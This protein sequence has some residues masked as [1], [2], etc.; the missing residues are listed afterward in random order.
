MPVTVHEQEDSRKTVEHTSHERRY[1]IRGTADEQEAITAL[2]ADASCPQAYQGMQRGD[3]DVWPDG[4][5]T[6][7]AAT[8]RWRARVVWEP[9]SGGNLRNV[10]DETV[11]F[12]IGGGTV[13]ITHSIA[14]VATYAVAGETAPDFKGGIG[15]NGSYFEGC[16]IGSGAEGIVFTKTRLFAAGQITNEYLSKV[17]ALRLHTNN[18]PFLGLAQGEVLFLGASGGTRADGKVEI[19]FRFSGSK[20]KADVK[21]CNDL[22]TV[23][24][25]PGWAYVW[26]WF[27]D[28]EQTVGGRKFVKPKPIAAYVERVHHEGDFANLGIGA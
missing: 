4:V 10:G 18:A 19:G 2:K 14:T 15:W 1:W 20:D 21:I 28:R 5:D 16:D 12:E 27:E 17:A 23:A 9:L 7:H 26:V 13:H 25:W 6:E 11:N 3:P 24:A 8:S 22:I